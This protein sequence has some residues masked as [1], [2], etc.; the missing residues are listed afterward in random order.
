M[1]FKRAV[2]LIE[3]MVVL[4]IIAI[5]IALALPGF[6]QTKERG[7]TKEAKANLK[8]IS[9]AEKIYRMKNAFYY[10]YSGSETVASNINESLKVK[11]FEENWDYSITKVG[12]YFTIYANRTAGA[13]PSCQYRLGWNLTDEPAPSNPGDCP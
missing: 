3:I 1:I 11:L 10:P 2:T 9:V 4:I 5:L 8:L 13:Y 7:L 12:S 6:N